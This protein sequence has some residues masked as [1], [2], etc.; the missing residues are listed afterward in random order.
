MKKYN[1]ITP[2]QF[3]LKAFDPLRINVLLTFDDGYQTW[4]DNCLPVLEAYDRKGLFF[5]NSGLLDS[6]EN[7]KVV[8]TYMKENLR[9]RPKQPLTWNGAELLVDKGHSIGGHSVSHKNLA[10]VDD[11]T[12]LLEIT[13]DKKRIELMLGVTLS[14]FAYPFGRKKNWNDD[15][16]SEVVRASYTHIYTADTGFVDMAQP[17]SINRVCIEKNQSILSIRWWIEGGYDIFKHI[18]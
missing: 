10:A 12:L 6:A 11:A 13:E 3:H 5:I 18:A 14:D 7:N 1:V 4:I 9:I 2:L 8:S 17:Y 15:V 16:Q